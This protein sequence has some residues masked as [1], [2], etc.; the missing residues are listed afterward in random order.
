MAPSKLQQLGG[1][2]WRFAGSVQADVRRGELKIAPLSK[3]SPNF[4]GQNWKRAEAFSPTRWIF[5]F[6]NRREKGVS[7]EARR[8]ALWMIT[9]NWSVKVNY[10]CLDLT[11]R[12][13]LGSE[14]C[15]SRE[16]ILLDKHIVTSFFFFVVKD[17]YKFC[18]N[19]GYLASW[20][21]GVFGKL[22]AHLLVT[23]QYFSA[24]H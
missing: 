8:D 21:T 15:V 10:A 3:H 12:S 17:I 2:H 23:K 22:G 20:L 4:Q 24:R 18:A 6:V 5:L 7:H 19:A 1:F 11:A 14:R 13:R 9:P 16:I